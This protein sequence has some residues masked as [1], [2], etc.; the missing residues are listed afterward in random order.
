MKTQNIT[1][2]GGLFILTGL[3]VLY[4]MKEVLG[5]DLLMFG[6]I[7]SIGLTVGIGY[8]VIYNQKA[9]KHI[10]KDCG[11]KHVLISRNR[12]N[13]TEIIQNGK[14]IFINTYEYKYHCNQCEKDTI[15]Q[16][17]VKMK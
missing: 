7:A 14:F 3:I 10:C 12:V 5:F 4:I 17:R 1:R 8:I 2:T 13:Q 16:K 6:I 15:I 9:N 11:I